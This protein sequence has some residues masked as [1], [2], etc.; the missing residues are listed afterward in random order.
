M[1]RNKREQV[2][3]FEDVAIDAR[4]RPTRTAWQILPA[5]R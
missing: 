5:Q 3:Q 4:L 1:V 2:D